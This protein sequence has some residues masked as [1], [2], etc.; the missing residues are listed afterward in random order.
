LHDPNPDLKL[1]IR[2]AGAGFLWVD[3]MGWLLFLLLVVISIPVFMS[4]YRRR[5]DVLG[6]PWIIGEIVQDRTR[7]LEARPAPVVPDFRVL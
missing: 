5:L 7:D 6:G 2:R 4:A 3:L 1:E